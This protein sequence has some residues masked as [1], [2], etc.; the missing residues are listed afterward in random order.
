MKTIKYTIFAIPGLRIVLRLCARLILLVLGWKIAG[1]IPSAPKYVLIAAPH[2][3]N[4]DF[5][6]ALLFALACQVNLCM[7][8]KKELTTWPLGYL[9][10]WLGVIPVD[11]SGPNNV[12]AQ[13]VAMFN[14]R[15]RMVLGISPPGTRSPVQQWKTGFYHIAFG[16]KVPISLGF[17]DYGRKIGGFGP[18]FTPSGDAEGDIARIRAFY[19]DIKGKN[20]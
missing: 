4:W 12:V 16:A 13:A 19:A 18:L 8:G 10:K 15:D 9:F 7:L 3:S 6:F 11:R 1:E 17:L 14:E 5:V 2:T 20:R